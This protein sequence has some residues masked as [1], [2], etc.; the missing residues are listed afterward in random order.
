MRHLFILLALLALPLHAQ[1]LP[2]PTAT[3]PPLQSQVVPPA[4]PQVAGPL[5][6]GPALIR[7]IVD[8]GRF[9]ALRWPDFSD[10]VKHLRNYYEPAYASA[11]TKN[12]HYT[13]Q[14]VAVISLFEGADEKGIHAAD[15]DGGRWAARLS[16]LNSATAT[17]LDAARFDL[18]VTINLMRYI[19]DLHIGRINPRNL[20][21]D[22]DIEGKKYYLPTLVG[23][24]AASA[25]PRAALSVV[26]PQYAE[27]RRLQKAYNDYRR[28]AALTANDKPLLV[29]K[30]LKPGETYASLHELVKLL[31]LVGDLPAGSRVDTRKNLYAEPVVAAIKRFQRRHGLAA[32][33]VISA[34]TFRELNVPL[35]QR[36]R[37]L[38]WAL[39]RWRWTP[40]EFSRPPI[41]V[42]VPEFVLRAWD[43]QGNTALAM[44]V[45]VGK[46]YTHETPIFEG[47]M[48]YLVMRPYWYVTPNIQRNELV[49]KL[50]KDPGYLARNHYEVV[51]DYDDPVGRTGVDADTLAKL[52]ANLLQ[53]RQKPG[54]DNSLGLIKFMF[55][56]QNNVYLHSTPAQTLF[57]KSRRDFS[58]GCIRVE[59]PLALAVWTLRD[60]PAWTRDTIKVAMEAGADNHTVLLKAPIPVFIIYTTATVDENGEVHFFDDIYG[61]DERL[62]TALAAGY[63]YP[64]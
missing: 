58:H 54:P 5:G 61:H 25:D 48:R 29:V 13:T 39:E 62:E 23:Q 19:S 12:G 51:A 26:E 7:S 28:G 14:A 6:A 27:Y 64:A 8:A 30:V 16:A 20:R 56:N 3:T 10:Y 15:Y 4:S 35:A 50:E 34:R 31:Q 49:P 11:W 38:E 36:V 33:G 22:L 42:N 63:P 59:D 57:S 52:R 24:I 2:A 55:P 1:Q 45:V 43:D 9:D 46:A 40:M 47:R 32:D 17:E 37:Q 60:D 41:I 53:V 44:N 18:L 21:F